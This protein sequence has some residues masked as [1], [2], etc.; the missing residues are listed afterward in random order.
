MNVLLFR[1]LAREQ[2]ES[3]R[4]DFPMLNFRQSTEAA[5]LTSDWA[6]VIFGNPAARDVAAL[7]NL[8]WLQIVSSGFD[9][10]TAL[11]DANITVTTA[12]GV[13]API[14][15][16]H[17][18]MTIL[19]FARGQPHLGQQQRAH[20]WDRR[21]TIPVDLARQTVGFIGYGEVGR[22][23]ARLLQPIGPRLIAVKRG[24]AAKPPELAALDTLEGLDAL[25]SGS[26]HVVVTLPLTPQT[27]GMLDAKRL[28]TMKRGAVLHNVARGGLVDEKALLAKLTDGSLG[29]AALDVFEN[30]PL[31]AE[32]PFWAM[33]NVLVT[34]HLAGHHRDLGLP[35]LERFRANLRRYVSDQ[36]LEHV[37]D[38][39]RGD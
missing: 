7:R 6:E 11:R 5:E 9:E 21:P 33:P 29:G 22:A 10:Y 38:F 13:H 18:L 16:Q 26:D 35:T 39:T 30:E 4:H 27:R 12:H 32:S 24:A 23:L 34:P 8:R 19:W 2:V 37:A 3:L 14:I 1:N 36:P 25:L 28:G 17:T 15:A 31:P 20:V